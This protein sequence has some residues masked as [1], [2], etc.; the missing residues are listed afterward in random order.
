MTKL[1]GLNIAKIVNDS[2]TSAGGVLSG[3][4]A[5][6]TPGT[7][8]PGSLTSGTNPSE[9][10]YAFKGFVETQARRRTGSE[11]ESGFAVVT[12]LGASVESSAVPEVNDVVSFDGDATEWT[13]LKLLSRD[14]AAA[15]YEFSAQAN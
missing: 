4:L 1:F 5:K 14:P 10:T 3:T 15:V 11:V 6:Q 7:R 12:I 9:A 2:I 13:L 8:T